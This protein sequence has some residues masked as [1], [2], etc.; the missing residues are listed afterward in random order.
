[1]KRQLTIDLDEALALEAERLARS[2][3]L[4]LASLI[5]TSLRDTLANDAP[6]AATRWRGRFRPSQRNDP[7]Y[8]ALAPK[9]PL[10]TVLNLASGRHPQPQ[11]QGLH[12][13]EHGAE[14]RVAV[15]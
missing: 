5:E 3:G 10:G 14:L 9:I 7:S 8:E 1:M 13:L 6:T 4:S 11:P 15:V 2:R 12:D